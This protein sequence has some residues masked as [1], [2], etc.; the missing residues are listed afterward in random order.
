MIERITY[1]G[2]LDEAAVAPDTPSAAERAL[3]SSSEETSCFEGAL[4]SARE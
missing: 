2:V 3:D 1:K 4:S